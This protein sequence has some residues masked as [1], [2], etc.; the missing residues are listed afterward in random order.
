LRK[1]EPAGVANAS[2]RE[3]EREEL[4]PASVADRSLRL[5]H[6]WLIRAALIMVV[7]LVA[8]VVVVVLLRT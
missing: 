5:R 6:P 7:V 1:P 4:F 3:P 2:G 8:L